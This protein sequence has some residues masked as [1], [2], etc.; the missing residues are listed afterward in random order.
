MFPGIKRP[1]TTTKSET[2]ASNELVEG[3]LSIPDKR[4][5]MTNAKANIFLSQY[6]P[7]A[8]ERW[9]GVD[10]FSH[11]TLHRVRHNQQQLLNLLEGN[12]CGTHEKLLQINK[13]EILLTRSVGQCLS[14]TSSGLLKEWDFD[15][16]SK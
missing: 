11:G 15:I 9:N 7:G 3:E 8:D 2:P 6:G 12:E 4:R 10:D 5:T 1:K 16:S 14:L 13:G